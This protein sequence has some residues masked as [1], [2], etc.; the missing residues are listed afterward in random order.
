MS[1]NIYHD[2]SDP[3]AR[4]YCT[5]EYATAWKS[6][7]ATLSSPGSECA[8]PDMDGLWGG[9]RSSYHGGHQRIPHHPG[10]ADSL[11]VSFPSYY[12]FANELG[13]SGGQ[14]HDVTD[15]AVFKEPNVVQRSSSSQSYHRNGSIS[16]SRSPDGS[17]RNSSSRTSSAQYLPCANPSPHTVS[18]EASLSYM[19]HPYTPYLPQHLPPG[20]ADERNDFQVPQDFTLTP[21]DLSTATYPAFRG[22]PEPAHQT[23]KLH[24]STTSVEDSSRDQLCNLTPP[25]TDSHSPCLYGEQ[26]A[27]AISTPYHQQSNEMPPTLPPVAL[28]AMPDFYAREPFTYEHQAALNSIG[29]S[30]ELASPKDKYTQGLYD[31]YRDAIDVAGNRGRRSYEALS[32]NPIINVQDLTGYTGTVAGNGPI[33]LWQFLLELLCDPACKHLIKWT[34]EGWQ[35]KMEEPDEVAKLWGI[36]KNK[37]KMTYEKLSRG[38]RYYYDKNI[39][40]KCQS[41]RYVYKY[42]NNLDSIL[43]HTALQIHKMLGIQ[44][45]ND[46]QDDTASPKEIKPVNLPVVIPQSVGTLVPASVSPPSSTE[47]ATKKQ[48]RSPQLP[49]GEPPFDYNAAHTSKGFVHFGEHGSTIQP[50]ESFSETSMSTVTVNMAVN[51]TAENLNLK[52]GDNFRENEKKPVFDDWIR[53]IA[54]RN[55]SHINNV[56]PTTSQDNNVQSNHRPPKEQHRSSVTPD[57]ET[58]RQIKAHAQ[59]RQEEVNNNNYNSNN[60]HGYYFNP[61]TSCMQATYTCTQ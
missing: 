19:Q 28:A 46:E 37:P 58:Q 53:E 14:Q 27:R 44:P 12:N 6:Y 15:H 41:R 20:P 3:S 2:I 13:R 31:G 30:S 55:P 36:R 24:G 11:H 60:N 38:I 42:V 8:F 32:V 18:A 23:S 61:H 49:T 33:Q 34:G 7:A 35:F 10:E 50:A 47:Q 16:Q 21:S 57:G 39:I 51:A 29:A 56:G 17:S 26:G 52:M 48:S 40:V 4:I 45:L 1:S 22:L 25:T 9:N 43:G 5:P 59:T 54:R